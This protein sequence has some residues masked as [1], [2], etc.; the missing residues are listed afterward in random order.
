MGKETKINVTL[1]REVAGLSDEV[2]VGY[3]TKRR[4]KEVF[5]TDHLRT[6]VF[7]RMATNSEILTH[8]K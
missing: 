5:V 4:V 3:G 2:L 1:E 6:L 7:E 8:I